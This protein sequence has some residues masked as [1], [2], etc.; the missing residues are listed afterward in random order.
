M[1]HSE[2]F[3]EN[4]EAVAWLRGMILQNPHPQPPEAFGR[5]LA[6]CGRHDAR[7]RLRGLE[8]PTHVIGSERDILVPVWKSQEVASLIPGA[9]LTLLPGAPHGASLERAEEF[10]ATALGFIREAAAAPA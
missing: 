4:P 3:Y 8:M 5:Q 7:D 9:K 2:E 6:A 1:N 10:N